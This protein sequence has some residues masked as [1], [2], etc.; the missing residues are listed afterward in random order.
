MNGQS[1]CLLGHVL[2][3]KVYVCENSVMLWILSEILPPVLF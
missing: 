3:Q 1:L 2:Q